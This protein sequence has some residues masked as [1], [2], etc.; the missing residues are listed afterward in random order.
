MF[1]FKD[2][3]RLISADYFDITGEIVAIEQFGSGHIND[4][5][6][7]RTEGT[8]QRDYLLQRI[9]HI[10]F[11]DVAGLMNNINNVL[12]HLKGKLA[13]L[14]QEEVEKRS[15]TLIPTKAGAL[16]YQDEADAYWRMFLLLKD[17]KSYDIV[18]TPKQAFSGGQAFGAFQKDLSDL[19]PNR[20]VA[21]LPNF[22]NI[23]FR[24]ANLRA[25]ISNDAVGRVAEVADLL[26]AIFTREARMRKVLCMGEAN[27]I[28]L[29][30]THNDTKF[31]NVLLDAQ[32]EVQCV[33]DLDTVMPG[34]VAYDFGDA[35]RTIINP[36]AEDTADL[37]AV[38]LNIPLFEAY[39]QGY[40]QEASSFLTTA[41]RDSLI[42]GVLLLPYMQAVRFLTDY[43]NGDTY[44]K[45]EYPTHNLVRT[46]TQL[47]LVEELEKQES[48]L[49]QIL[50][51]Y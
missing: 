20:L 14:E 18:E 2:H 43:I 36:A 32:D 33:I 49:I 31:N 3:Q 47:K 29:R 45:V 11:P 5:F 25:A 51:K 50:Q 46:K 7:V 23:D 4:T 37:D 13:H 12:N 6:R 10:I 16:F 9:N 41:E 27:E 35:I 1:E 48:T 17:T 28:P 24:I 34:Y 19:D 40:L 39:A 42:H 21:I 8:K 44:Y 26:H 22:H 15:L 30:I 38:V